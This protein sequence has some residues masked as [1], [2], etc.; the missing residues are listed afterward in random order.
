MVQKG[1]SKLFH[2]RK[3]ADLTLILGGERVLVH[4]L[5]ICAWSK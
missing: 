5:V 1:F 3:L 4:K 2:D